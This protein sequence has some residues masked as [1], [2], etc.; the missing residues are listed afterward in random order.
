MNMWLLCESRNQVSFKV[1][2]RLFDLLFAVL[3]FTISKCV[4][5]TDSIKKQPFEAWLLGYCLQ[6]A[7]QQQTLTF[8]RR[9]KKMCA[10]K[11]V[12]GKAA[13]RVL[14]DTLKRRSTGWS[15]LRRMRVK[16][17]LKG[18]QLLCRKGVRLLNR[19][20]KIVKDGRRV[21]CL[22]L[23]QKVLIHL[24]LVQFGPKLSLSRAALSSAASS[25]CSFPSSSSPIPPP[26]FTRIPATPPCSS[27]SPHLS[28]CTSVW[29]QTSSFPV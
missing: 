11:T 18:R 29:L 12:S 10:H 1:Q 21:E 8:S 2:D 7:N 9:T 27:L 14:R 17:P 25:P 20:M 23:C 24:S 22:C 19:D 3:L 13:E 6:H 4:L 5:L 16:I 26:S 28:P 15:R